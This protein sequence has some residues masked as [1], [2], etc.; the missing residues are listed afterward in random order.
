[1]TAS[2]Q[3]RID[4]EYARNVKQKKSLIERARALL[5]SS[6]SRAAIEEVKWLQ[7]KWKTVGPV[8]R[9]E[10]RALWETFREQCDAVFQKRQQEF[11]S[12][13]AQLELDALKEQAEEHLANA[14]HSPKRGVEVLKSTLAQQGN[15][16][17]AA[18][19]SALRTL[20]IRAEI[21]TDTPTPAAD[22]TLRRDYQ[23]QRLMRSMGQGVKAEEGEL[24]TLTIEWLSVGPTDEA[25]YVQLVERLKECRRRSHTPCA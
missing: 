24:E 12:H 5:A 25:T 4:A 16:D 10:D 15:S 22:Q 6:D 23:V 20:C 1:L 19:E 18:N 9:D 7:E 8:R 13:A 2:L 14:A 21:L 11:A 17:V 3:S